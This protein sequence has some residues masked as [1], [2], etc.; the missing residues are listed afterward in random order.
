MR[1]T[2]MC[3][4]EARAPVRRQ[5]TKWTSIIAFG[6]LAATTVVL[7]AHAQRATKDEDAAIAT[8]I[9]RRLT[10]DRDV[11]AQNVRID[12]RDGVVT[13]TGRVPG[14]DAKQRAETVA[15]TVPG[16]AEVRN[17]ITVGGGGGLRGD[18]GPGPI[19]DEMPRAR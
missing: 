7:P 3:T 10:D 13:L 1:H 5:L 2:R 4:R 9:E 19:P 6:C 18:G 8:E 17:E 15:A 12:T 14:D 16:V 11:N